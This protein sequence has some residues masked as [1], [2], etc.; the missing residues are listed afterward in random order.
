MLLTLT[1]THRPA[2]DLGYLLH[3]NPA[4][5]HQVEL[6]FG[7]AQMFYPEAND[8]RC[9]FA[10]LLDVDPVGLVRGR[11]KDGE[12]LLTQ[13]VND[14]PYALSSFLSVAISRGLGTALGGRSKH[15]PELVDTP[16]PL[17]ARLTP[18]PCRGGEEVLR[19]LFEPLGY[20]VEVETSLLDE[21]FPEWGP[22]AYA[23]VTLTQTC[24]L[25][26]LLSHIYVLVPVLDN[27]KH[28][29]V[30]DEE[31]E[32]LL[33][34]GEGWLAAHPEKEFIV[35]RYLK[36]RGSLTRD[37]LAQLADDDPDPDAAQEAHAAE[38]EQGEAPLS[39]NQQRLQAV[40]AALRDSGARSV[41]DLGCGEGR[42]LQVLMKEKQFQRI[43]GMD[44][45]IRS[46][47]IAAHHLK[48]ERIPEHQ[49]ERLSLMH[50]SLS[51]RDRRLAGFDAAV[52]VEVVE[53]LDPPRLGA[54][55]RA[56]FQ[57][58]RPPTVI[59]TTPNVEYNTLFERLPA[60]KLRHSDHRFE[61]TRAEF[62]TWARAIA[63][64]NGYSVAFQPIGPVDDTL[65]APTQMGIFSQCA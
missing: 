17:E 52:A 58:A 38:E 25:A 46:L 42:L 54:F 59:I 10:M 36:H 26:D 61:W 63:A 37:A 51:Y 48:L 4:N 1:T 7:S 21:R 41:A 30:G 39:L 15:R 5:L 50:G 31:V 8:E 23:S 13:Y 19:R 14:R 55:E 9:T 27:Q 32:K 40:T 18:L 49:R 29:W 6:A 3:K 35:R 45:S 60:G 43:V 53:H 57:Y 28:Y 33:R 64:R 34:H 56:L 2:T 20:G 22:G 44:V 65:G 47:E 16:I 62:E 24:R 12:G 11:G